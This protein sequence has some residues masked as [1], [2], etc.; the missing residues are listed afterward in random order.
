MAANNAR[1]PNEDEVDFHFVIQ[2]AHSEDMVFQVAEVNT[3]LPS[4]A[5]LVENNYCVT[6]D[7]DTASGK[8]SSMMVHKPS[9]R[10]TR[11]RR[12]RN[13]RMTDSV[14]ESRGFGRQAPAM[15]GI[16]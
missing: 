1:I 10:S 4:I 9:G 15:N 5:Y 3:A 16:P 7:K 12:E 14:V 8:D 11:F 6:F 2:E 13:I